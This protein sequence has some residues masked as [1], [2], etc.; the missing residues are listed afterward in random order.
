MLLSMPNIAFQIE[1][2]YAA[3][4]PR[5]HFNSQSIPN[6]NAGKYQSRSKD[7]HVWNVLLSMQS[8]CG[9]GHIVVFSFISL[10]RYCLSLQIVVHV[11]HLRSSCILL[12]KMRQDGRNDVCGI[13]A[14]DSSESS[15]LDRCH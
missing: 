2:Y 3:E 4:K 14:L 6:S 7:G 12:A 15:P 8:T 1:R 10:H 13:I 11:Y 5:Q 9:R